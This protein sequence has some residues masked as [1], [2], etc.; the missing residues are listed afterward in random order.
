MQPRAQALVDPGVNSP[1]RT[2]GASR[3]ALATSKWCAQ[4]A[5]KAE[6]GMIKTSK[7]RLFENVRPCAILRERMSLSKLAG[8]ARRQ[9]GSSFKR[10]LAHQ[11]S[12]RS[13]QGSLLFALMTTWRAHCR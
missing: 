10:D 13:A 8:Y 9:M 2:A 7:K 5:G 4:H 3:V 12:E 11:G 1:G 6:N